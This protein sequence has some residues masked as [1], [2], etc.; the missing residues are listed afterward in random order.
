LPS[1]LEPY[2]KFS[3]L[4]TKKICYLRLLSSSAGFGECLEFQLRQIILTT[5]FQRFMI[6]VVEAIM[7]NR[8]KMTGIGSQEAELI[9]TIGSSGLKVFF[10]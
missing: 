10:G 4:L 1:V 2:N 8:K 6:V 7:I 5:G 3:A 9:A